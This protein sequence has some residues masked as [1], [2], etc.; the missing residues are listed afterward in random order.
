MSDNIQQQIAE[1]RRQQ[2]LLLTYSDQWWAFAKPIAELTR[3]W[4]QANT[5]RSVR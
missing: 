5:L 1:L 3:Q 2:S 4:R